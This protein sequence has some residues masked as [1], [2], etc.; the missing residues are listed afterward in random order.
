MERGR[1]RERDDSFLLLFTQDSRTNLRSCNSVRHQLFEEND[2]L[3]E[4]I[5]RARSRVSQSE[6]EEEGGRERRKREGERGEE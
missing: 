4:Q 6:G 2:S 5:A 3:N 1:K